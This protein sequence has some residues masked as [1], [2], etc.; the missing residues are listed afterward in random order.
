[1]NQPDN[2]TTS[3]PTAPPSQTQALLLRLRDKYGMT[4]DEIQAKSGV[5][6]ARV[7]RWMRGLVPDSVD[8]VHRLQ[9]LE[10]QMELELKVK[11]KAKH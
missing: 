9:D 6:Q 4:Q 7:S 11:P 1:M 10:R 8:D 5:P 3:K 2:T